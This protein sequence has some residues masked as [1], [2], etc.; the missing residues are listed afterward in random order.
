MGNSMPGT[1]HLDEQHVHLTFVL[2]LWAL[3]FP[4]VVAFCSSAGGSGFAAPSRSLSGG[5]SDALFHAVDLGR[6]RSARVRTFAG[7]VM[8]DVRWDRP[9]T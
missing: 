6:Q 1:L 3:G 7:R 5:A 4:S 2:F 8:V 9:E